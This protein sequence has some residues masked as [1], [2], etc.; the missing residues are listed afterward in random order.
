MGGCGGL[1]I[2]RVPC[3]P[4]TLILIADGL[5]LVRRSFLITQNT[6]ENHMRK[7][8]PV[9]FLHCVFVIIHLIFREFIGIYVVFCTFN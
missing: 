9:F 8:V 5:N 3:I 6:S 2:I 4:T 7:V 1:H